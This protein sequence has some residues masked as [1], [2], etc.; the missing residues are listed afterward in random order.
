MRRRTT[1]RSARTTSAGYGATSDPHGNA[2]GNVLGNVPQ[3]RAILGKGR[4]RI[5]AFAAKLAV[6]INRATIANGATLQI[7]SNGTA[8]QRGMPHCNGAAYTG[9]KLP[10]LGSAKRWSAID[11]YRCFNRLS[12]ARL[13]SYDH[14]RKDGLAHDA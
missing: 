7:L 11:S 12:Q 1:R 5:V 14:L 9:A 3:I 8:P 2:L 4:Q 6:I 13:S 10:Q